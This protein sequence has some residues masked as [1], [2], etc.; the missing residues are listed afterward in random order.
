MKLLLDTH[1]LLWW[2]YDHRRLSTSAHEAISDGRNEVSVSAVSAM[3][4]ATKHRSGKLT[5]AGALARDF[6]KQV[7]SH[8]FSLV[9]IECE[10]AQ[11]AGNFPYEHRDPW[12][13]LL[14]AQSQIEGLTLVS[15]DA[16]LSV[17]GA[18]TLW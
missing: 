14:A 16:K 15:N 10:H 13:R 4:I 6:V 11:R 2:A 9:S 3:E 18:E 5:H 7:Q 8:G 1:A 12:D 17:L